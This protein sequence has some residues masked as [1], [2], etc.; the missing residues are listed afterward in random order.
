MK[1][2]NIIVSW[3]VIVLIGV[4]SPQRLA[5]AH[6]YSLAQTET[7]KAAEGQEPSDEADVDEGGDEDFEEDEPTPP[8]GAP[9]GSPSAPAPSKTPPPPATPD[10]PPVEPSPEP[11]LQPI[12]EPPPPPPSGISRPGKVKL[13]KKPTKS[14]KEKTSAK[15]K[16]GGLKTVKANCNMR[17]TPSQKGKKLG[18]VKTGRKIWTES[19]NAKWFKVLRQNGE[20]AYINRECF[21]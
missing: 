7:P 16:G 20:A 17:K 10:S 8:T 4:Y 13:K 6:A 5:N 18:L 1:P 9:A 14:I 3:F 21:D 15:G 19:A 2:F 11:S 12:P